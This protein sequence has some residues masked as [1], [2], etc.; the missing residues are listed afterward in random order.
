[1]LIN[2]FAIYVLAFGGAAGAYALGWSYIY[3]P[4]SIESLTFLALSFLAAGMLAA[5]T[6]ST[7]S[8]IHVIGPRIPDWVIVPLALLFY[9]DIAY[10][11]FP[12]K[13]IAE[14]TFEY[15]S[16]ELGIPHIHVF[17]GT[18]AIT[19]SAI[20]FSDFLATR[21][22]RYLLEAAIP[23]A[24]LLMIVYRGPAMICFVSWGF[25]YLIMRK[26]ALPAL[27]ALSVVALVGLY[28]FGLF[29]DFRQQSEQQILTL[30][31]ASEGFERS[32]VPRAFFWT[33]TYLTAPLAN[34]QLAT[35]IKNLDVR[36]APE[37]LV[38][39][40]LPDVLSKRTLPLLGPP[41][42]LDTPQ[43]S[44]GINV[45][46]IF[47]R[48]AVYA[49]WPGIIAMFA[50]FCIVVLVYLRLIRNSALAVPSLAL[51]NTLVVFCTFENMIAHSGVFLQI[52]WPPLLSALFWQ[53][54]T[55]DGSVRT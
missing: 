39:E 33:Y 37:F 27:A 14:E 55:P 34:L 28:L 2:P 47:G 53:A 29:G 38:S 23:I 9:G 46:T 52:V 18:F 15:A 12:L 44:P 25:V 16:A 1:M 40:F 21:R 36:S 8:R 50:W 22:W 10:S 24:Y 49:G 6:Y 32:G 19:F 11:G 45:A 48:A 35:D 51:L 31:K 30:G 41:R 20:R 3:P 43:V 54:P 4:F 42:R 17:A 26:P 13:Q 5:A 7:T